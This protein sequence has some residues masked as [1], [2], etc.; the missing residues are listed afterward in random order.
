MFWGLGI[1]GLGVRGLG[2]GGLGPGADGLE[3]VV[4][5]S[6]LNCLAFRA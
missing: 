1:W 3:V 4:W 6:G 2:F 5:D